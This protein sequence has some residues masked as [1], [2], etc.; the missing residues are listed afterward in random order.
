MKNNTVEFTDIKPELQNLEVGS[1]L[2]NAQYI[3]LLLKAE[4]DIIKERLYI[5]KFATA[6]GKKYP[7][8][9]SGKPTIT[10]SNGMSLQIQDSLTEIQT[11][12]KEGRENEINFDTLAYLEVEGETSTSKNLSGVF[13]TLADIQKYVTEQCNAGLGEV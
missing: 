8:S 12:L 13:Y 4:S 2:D 10:N 7:V 3:A 9:I 1:K 11:L 6:S 5:G